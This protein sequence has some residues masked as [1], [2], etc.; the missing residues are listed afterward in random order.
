MT[1]RVGQL[2]QRI[3]PLPALLAKENF[4][5]TEPLTSLAAT[6]QLTTP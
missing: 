1:R 4:D 6:I 3:C 5:T 2:F